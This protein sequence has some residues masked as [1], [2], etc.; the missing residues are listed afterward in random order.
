[1]KNWKRF[2][3]ACLSVTMVASIPLTAFAES[4]VSV[5]E[6]APKASNESETQEETDLEKILS[7]E[8]PYEYF[9]GLKDQEKLLDAC[10]D[11][12]LFQLKE[13]MKYAYIHE[14]DLKNR[15]SLDAY[16]TI[17]ETWKNRN[18]TF[19]KDEQENLLQLPEKAKVYGTK[20]EGKDEEGKSVEKTVKDFSTYM[21]YL[22]SIKK[23]DVPKYM[24]ILSTF[25]EVKTK[26]DLAKAKEAYS[27]FEEETFGF[28][29]QEAEPKKEDS[30]VDEQPAKE[31]KKEDSKAEQSAKENPKEESKNADTSKKET[32]S[33]K[34]SAKSA[35]KIVEFVDVKENGHQ[36]LQCH[37]ISEKEKDTMSELLPK[38]VKAKMENGDIVGIDVTWKVDEDPKTTNNTVYTY[39]I[40][41]PEK[42]SIS[43][44]LQ[45]LMDME[46]SRLPFIYIKIKEELEKEGHQRPF[47]REPIRAS[48]PIR[49]GRAGTNANGFE[50][51]Y[52][53]YDITNDGSKIVIKGWAYTASANQYG[54]YQGQAGNSVAATKDYVLNQHPEYQWGGYCLEVR[55]TSGGVV[56]SY[57]LTVTER[58]DH[59]DLWKGDSRNPTLIDVAFR[60]DIPLSDLVNK[61]DLYL[62]LHYIHPRVGD[63]SF[64][65]MYLAPSTSMTSGS[66]RVDFKAD[67]ISSFR[68][69]GTQSF[70]NKDPWKGNSGVL[71]NGNRLYYSTND[72][73]Y[74]SNGT[75]YNGQRSLDSY[76]TTWFYTR[77]R[78]TGVTQSD[79][80]MHR[81]KADAGGSIYGWIP[82][83]FIQYN[84][85]NFRL[86]VSYNNFTIT[87]NGNGGTWNSTNT[88]ST[89]VTY[90]QPYVTESNFFT[91]PG[92]HF[93]GWNE[94]PTGSSTSWTDWIGKPWTWTLAK[95]ITLYAQWTP[96][97]A[98]ITYNVQGGTVGN[99]YGTNQ[100]GHVSKNGDV[101]FDSVSYG[102]S[103]DPYDA[104]T[105]GLTKTGYHFGGWKIRSTGTIL[106]QS[107]SYGSTTYVDVDNASLSTANRSEVWCYLDAVWIPNRVQIAYNPNGGTV[108]ASG[109]GYN[110]YGWVTQ[111]GNTYFHYVDYGTDSDPYNATTF[112]LTKPGYRFAGWRMEPNG[113]ILDQ[114]TS[115]GSTTYCHYTNAGSNTSNMYN[116]TCYLYAHWV[117]DSYTNYISHWLYGFNNEGTN[118]DKH[119]FQ[120]GS[121][122]FSAINGNT[123]TLGAN[124]A[125][126][127]P[128]GCFVENY[129][130]TSS[131]TGSWKGYQ[132][133]QSFTQKPASMG[134]QYNYSPYQYDINYNLDGGTNNSS[135]PSSYNVLYGLTLKTPTKTGYKFLGWEE[136]LFRAKDATIYNGASR[137]GETFT[138]TNGTSGNTFT[139]SKVQVWT[140]DWSRYIA[141]PVSAGAG[142]HNNIVGTYTHTEPTGNYMINVAA[143]GTT[144]DYSAPLKNVYLEKGK[145]YTFTIGSSTVSSNKVTIG[146]VSIK[147]DITGINAG[148]SVPNPVTTDFINNELPTRKIGDVK[149]TATWERTPYLDV[150]AVINGTEYNIVPEGYFT[151]DVYINGKLDANDVNDYWTMWP[152]GTKYE[153]KD[154]KPA[155]NVKYLGATKGTSVS[156]TVTETGGNIPVWL[157]FVSTHT[158][159]I[160]H[161][162]LG[163]KGAD[164][165]S[166]LLGITQFDATFGTTYVMDDGR[167]TK[168][169]N[170]YKLYPQFR[171]N[172]NG[173][174]ENHDIGKTMTQEAKNMA[175]VYM[176]Q[177]INYSISYN[178]DGGTNNAA[179]P[180]TYNVLNG[181][182]LKAPTKP[183]YKFLGWYQ[184][185]T[186]ITGI[187]EGKNATFSSVDEM[188]AELA[189]RTTGNV[190]LTAKWTPNKLTVRYHLNGG[191]D[192]A[193]DNIFGS[194]DPAKTEVFS[195][196]T[197]NAQ[198]GL[199]DIT[200]ARVTPPTGYRI[201]GTWNT[202]ADG[203]GK[204]FD[205]TTIY[206]LSDLTK[207]IETGDAVIDLYAQWTENVLTVNYYSNYATK[208]FTGALNEVGADK[209]VLVRTVTY[210]ATA[211]CSYGLHDYYTTNAEKILARD[212][213]TGT[214]NWGTKTD[215]GIL[216]NQ[217]T[218]FKT[219]MELA[220]ALGVDITTQNATINVYPQWTKNTLTIQYH[221][222]GG[223]LTN[224]ASSEFTCDTEGYLLRSGKRAF[225][226]VA[227][228]QQIAN[229]SNGFFD[230]NNPG[231]LDINKVGYIAKKGAEWNTKSDGT[232]KSFNQT[233]PYIAKDVTD[234]SKGS[235]TLTVY[236]NWTPKKLV[237]TFHK[238]DGST[239]TAT[240]TFTYDTAGQKFSDKKW[241]RTGYTLLGW[242]DSKT[243]TTAQYS[244]LSGVTNAWI[245]KHYPEND[246]YAVW[247]PHTYTIVY[248]GNGATGG[249]TPSSNHTYD[250]PQTLIPNGFTKP[251]YVF[252]SWN[253]EPDGTGNSY[254]D[255]EEVQNLTSKDGDTIT[256]HAQWKPVDYKIIYKGNGSTGGTEKTHL[257]NQKD[258]EANGYAVKTNK[259]YTDFVRTN[260]T[261]MGWYQN[262]VVDTKAE[263]AK[264]YK[265]GSKLTYSQLL[266]IHAEQV[267]KGLVKETDPK[268]KEIILYSVW[269]EA[270]SID[271]STMKKSTFYEGVDITR[272]ELLDGITASD[273]IDGSLTSQI[274]ITRIDYSAGKLVNGKKQAAY[275]QTWANGMPADAKLDTWFM[276]LDKN[277]SPVTHT[278]TYQVKDSAGNITTA[279]ETIQVVYNEFPT[280]KAN[281]FKFTLDDAQAGLVTKDKLLEKAVASGVISA[282]DVEDGDMKSKIELIDYDANAFKT[283]KQEGFIPITYQ[284]QDSMGPGGKG[285]VALK[286]VNVNIY[287]VRKEETVRYVRFI[288]K[289]YYEKNANL[290]RNALAGK[291]DQI[292]LLSVNG[293][294]HPFSVWYTDP[295]YRA[296]ITETF[297]KTKGTTYVYTKDDIKKMR[298]FVK[299]HGVG[300]AKEEDALSKFAD[301]FMT[302]DYILK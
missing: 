172:N 283:M 60:F 14:S 170:G 138:F 235:V 53:I 252:D 36:P 173:V 197:T 110:Q 213:Y 292:A 78:Y 187:N 68:T 20:F 3:A 131:V 171:Y 6:L 302:G 219:G 11:E 80:W 241:T 270:P 285:K 228:D 298:E 25:D 221:A 102:N 28:D 248:N 296:L 126:T 265:Q 262:S 29:E 141:Q 10:K 204:S 41:L 116:V 155:S 114:D 123:F 5:K 174:Y 180:S 63:A 300:N 186:K 8:K 92:Y 64:Y 203:S 48:A 297:E 134:F 218:G 39:D 12:E 127:P 278:V 153:I 269:D 208:G 290:D 178:L 165:E 158:N 257:Y 119:A 24:E 192:V 261:F 234:L 47:V 75:W 288:N 237:T 143:N 161:R 168:I 154:V 210:P 38:A 239:I 81:T 281:D 88:W 128:H 284:V 273:K 231:G 206:K 291:Y 56:G 236:V 250:K 271:T 135:N 93:V 105:F 136:D 211:E 147:G 244:I 121:T 73:F 22:Q 157:N 97:I 202:K 280:I 45:A 215:G 27:N 108:S 191:T 109:Y 258:V 267:K 57:P 132:F 13:Y 266:A 69:T 240:Q 200:T 263:M 62:N 106:D 259:G 194:G 91:R 98:H 21:E 183:G 159:E 212:F 26:E 52:E 287:L 140:N 71:Y 227:F 32:E 37:I 246:V 101:W 100:Y 207:D 23:F 243:A 118:G 103:T 272:T 146:N 222:N 96:N 177:A 223:T 149:L 225:Q 226:N 166:L 137:N 43:D 144:Q 220:K 299:Q 61:G 70:V 104:S 188:Y 77:L 260:H 209:N 95:N 151:F 129:I 156:G 142:T 286:T 17:S 185:D 51:D 16:L 112:G 162:M 33:A 72:Y 65:L 130:G 279:K 59:T 79:G 199:A 238:N 264:I 179:S 111:N 193:S 195:Y 268:V 139:A 76:K 275:S 189:K 67:N 256:L 7:Q 74:L 190:S 19:D 182:S 196:P 294:L 230:W 66:Y 274:I 276:Q 85:S 34:E 233:L 282:S 44:Q 152:L 115:Y 254:Q 164:G 35:T 117:P 107:T 18:V 175:Y 150:N 15:Q 216:V 163:V 255:K 181:V 89:S 113:Q 301:I 90:G 224:L 245:E 145:T 289:E 124:N 249:S 242:A 253:T 87:Y 277:D 46:Q 169:P 232:G 50:F 86:N 99:G 31:D 167:A 176:Y 84:C 1:M 214:G 295:T 247:K 82:S 229:E 58:V 184:G 49:K 55:N 94:S 40:Q 293:G 83:T 54:K 160:W 251:G 148:K 120:I 198:Y 125:V 9:S 30:K 2:I 217:S 122:S 201:K 42:Y 133:G 205:F 4:S